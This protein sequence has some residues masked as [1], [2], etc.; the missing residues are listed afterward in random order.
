MIEHNQVFIN[1]YKIDTC[2]IIEKLQELSEAGIKNYQNDVE[3]WQLFDDYEID[4]PEKKDIITRIFSESRVGVIYGS[5][6]VG[7]STMK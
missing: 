7:K 1:E 3:T 2:T 5:A 6:G 4:C